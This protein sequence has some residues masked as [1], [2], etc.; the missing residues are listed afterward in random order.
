MKPPFSTI[1]PSCKSHWSG[2]R[3]GYV[4]DADGKKVC[5]VIAFPAR[6]RDEQL[7]LAEEIAA[8]LNRSCK[9]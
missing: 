4:Y 3:T 9:C 6:E 8:I 2:K 7:R 5:Y 1:C